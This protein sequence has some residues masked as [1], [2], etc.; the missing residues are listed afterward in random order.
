MAKEAV[1]LAAS[2]AIVFGCMPVTEENRHSRPR[3]GAAEKTLILKIGDMPLAQFLGLVAESDGL[4]DDEKRL[5]RSRS[6]AGVYSHCRLAKYRQA[7][8]LFLEI[9]QFNPRK[10]VGADPAGRPL[11]EGGSGSLSRYELRDGRWTPVSGI[12]YD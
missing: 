1:V 7:G 3:T 11:V 6:A 2:A 4:S 8:K 10:E 5:I 12:E 9:D